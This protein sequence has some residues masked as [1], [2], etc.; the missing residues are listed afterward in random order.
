MYHM[1]LQSGLAI[2]ILGDY[3]K[4]FSWQATS[5]QW[6]LLCTFVYVE[7][8]SSCHSKHHHIARLRINMDY[9]IRHASRTSL[10][11]VI[12]LGTI[13]LHFRDRVMDIW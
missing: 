6:I 9:V 8:E 4:H 10:H 12:R 3:Q 7:K 2:S 11:S 5:R 1:K 13:Q